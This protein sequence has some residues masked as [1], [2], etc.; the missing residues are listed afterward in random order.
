MRKRGYF[1][2]FYVKPSQRIKAL[3]ESGLDLFVGDSDDIL[4]IKWP[5]PSQ[6]ETNLEHRVDT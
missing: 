5:D 1:T 3:E 6:E 2:I 4:Q